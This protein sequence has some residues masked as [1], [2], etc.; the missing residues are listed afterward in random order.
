MFKRGEL[1]EQITAKKLFGWSDKQ[2]AERTYQCLQHQNLL[3]EPVILSMALQNS[4]L[5]RL[6]TAIE[7]CKAARF[8][9][10]SI[11]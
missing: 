4:L 10:G 8:S 2:Y 11:E 1:P 5:G 3:A 6:D 9:G 7:F